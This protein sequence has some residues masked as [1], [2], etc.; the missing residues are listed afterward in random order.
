MILLCLAWVNNQWFALSQILT[1]LINE[2][3]IKITS[4]HR[5]TILLCIGHNVPTP[6][7]PSC[8]QLVFEK[9]WSQAITCI[10]FQPWTWCFIGNPVIKSEATSGNVSPTLW[11][12]CLQHLQCDMEMSAS[13]NKHQRADCESKQF[14][15]I[16]I[17]LVG[18]SNKNASYVPRTHKW[19][20]KSK[21]T[22]EERKTVTNGSTWTKLEKNMHSTQSWHTL[23]RTT[24]KNRKILKNLENSWQFW[25]AESLRKKVLGALEDHG[26]AKK[27]NNIDKSWTI[28]TILE[29]NNN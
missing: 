5:T 27:T 24:I 25:N 14:K 26:K 15:Q 20:Q 8:K 11:N 23:H 6:V 29:K 4:D 7:R 28:M 19:K 2:Q 17:L 16:T 21:L 1:Q 12:R 3:G 10:F 13:S 9:P 22:T 18:F